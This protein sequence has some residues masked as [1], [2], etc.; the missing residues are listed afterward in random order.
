MTRLVVVLAVFVLAILLGHCHAQAQTPITSQNILTPTVGAWSG[1]VAGQ[2]GGYSGGG[3]G[4]AYNQTTNTL[5]FG[6]TTA[7]ATQRISAEAFAIQHALDLSN[8]GIKINGYNYSW[9]INNSG[10]Q[11]GTLSGQV[12]M[13]RGNTALESYTYNYNATTEGFELKT[14]TQTFTNPQSL[15]AGD[16]MRLSFT[17]KDSRFWAGYYGPQVRNP[18]LTLN[19]TTDPCLGNPLY[20]PS[21]AG[22]SNVLT[23]QTIA[24]QTYAINQALDLAGAGVKI[25]GFEYGYNYYVGGDYCHFGFIICFET[26]PSSMDIDVS[27]TSNAG[28]SL[29]SATH[30]HGPNTSGSP[31][32]SYV[33][34]QQRLLSTM[35]NFSL[36]TREVG[37]TALY[38]SWSRWQYTPDPCTIDPLSSASCPGY[39]AAYQVQQCTINPLFNAACPGYAQA[40]FI[41]QCSANALSDASCPGYASAYLTY[42]CTI[43]PLYSTTCA[44]YET[45]YFDQQCSINPLYNTRCTGYA[46]AYHNQQCTANPLYS[47][48]CNGYAD[49]YKAQQCSLDGL[50]DR[51]CPNYSTAYATKMVLEQQGTASI[52][53]TAGTVA[54]NDPAN[55]PV[56][57]TT[58]STTVGSDGAVSVGVS[59]TGDSN[60]DKA[61]APPPPSTNS[62]GAPAAAVQLAPPPP[63]PQQQMAQNEPRG[64]KGG[65]DKQEDKKDDAPKGTGGNS[66]P[67]NINTTQ[68]SSDR[69]AAPTVRQAIQ[70]RREAAAK[71]EAVEKGKNLAN[72]MGKASDMESQKAVQNVVIQA[73]GFTPGFDAYS[74]QMIVQQQFYPVV[75]VY[76]NQK[77]ID[78]RYTARMFGGTDKLHNEMV[79]KQ[80]ESK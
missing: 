60:V 13:M 57:T 5:I 7:T 11:S 76:N 51:T 45:A 19:Y 36:T 62:A 1:S 77:N 56:S 52:V 41:Q 78:N 63:A 2:N 35:G 75:S 15:L 59:K 44:G 28:T 47:T 80:Y 42:Q 39:A 37:T 46:S 67:P 29:Y 48:T 4:P 10:Q 14:G 34:P 12:Q 54:R 20:S 17:G 32:Y 43:N 30:S 71:A 38:S 66:P 74:R 70:E 65:N 64:G 55:A 8:S 3:N 68:A 53:A 9:Q 49:A 21:C 69:P 73:M 16:S 79:E 40:V 23:S 33:F 58:A 26:R 31:S 22:Y 25:N 6:Y 61:I 72:E 50:Y 18:S 27:V 24:A